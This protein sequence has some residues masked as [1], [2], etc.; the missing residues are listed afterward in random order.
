[1]R[2]STALPVI[3]MLVLASTAY[4]QSPAPQKQPQSQATQEAPDAQSPQRFKSVLV[5]DVQDLPPSV[6]QQVD[7][8]SAQMSKDDMDSLRSSIDAT[9]EASSALKEKGITSAQV[10]A[11]AV[12][13][14][15]TLT[16]VTRKAT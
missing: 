12:G 1:M 2:I 13:Q 16:L 14:D 7:A 11:A 8:A 4:A 9:P 5:V 10:V 3:T 6:Q 15:G